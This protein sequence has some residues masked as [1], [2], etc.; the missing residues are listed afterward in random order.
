M[1]KL[2]IKK[3]EKL[4]SP[5]RHADGD[6]LYLQISDTGVK[7]W[8]FRFKRGGRERYMGLGVARDV[9]LAEAREA[10]RQARALLRKGIDP[11]D[12][13]QAEKTARAL[14]AAKA[15][16]FEAAAREYYKQ[17]EGRWKN[18][19]AT[20]QFLST[21]GTYAFP[22]IGKLP[23]AAIDTAAVLRVLE[24]AHPDEPDKSFWMA[25]PETAD[26]T[27]GRIEQILDWAGVRGFRTGDNPARLRG[28][29]SE[30]LPPR[31]SIQRTQHHPALPFADLPA[32]YADLQ[33]REG[34]AAKALEWTILTAARTGE[35]IGAVWDEIDFDAKLWTVP[36]GRI[37][38]GKEHRV[39]LSDRAIALLEKLPR[40]D[41]N[42]YLFVGPKRGGGLSN[43]ALSSVLKRMGRTDITVH[44]FRSCFRDWAAE[45]TAYPNHVVEMALAHVVG[46]AV[47]AAYRRGDLLDKRRRLMNEWSRYA[48]TPPSEKDA[49]V[50]SLSP[51]KKSAA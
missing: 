34:V 36:G 10:A 37:K 31:S 15:I 28:H 33:Q 25:R 22:K 23:V 41:D 26:R 44:G 32:F 27:R 6:N 12:A 51:V 16:S 21:L 17:H 8:L 11:L 40:E 3:V 2:T 7:S 29:L 48:T 18:A 19:K 9:S 5:G 47:E 20:K 24:Q 14:E 50:V 35:T 30:V 39:P 49:K 43:M 46:N 4:S 1:S 45:R 42:P 38:G 13:K